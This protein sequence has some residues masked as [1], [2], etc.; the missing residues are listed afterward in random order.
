M[1]IVWVP[2]PDSPPRRAAEITF[3]LEGQ[4]FSDPVSHRRAAAMIRFVPQRWGARRW[5]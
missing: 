2:P 1:V 3:R 4:L 5:S